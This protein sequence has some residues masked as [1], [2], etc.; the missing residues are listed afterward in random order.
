LPSDT[1]SKNVKDKLRSSDESATMASE[2]V[3]SPYTSEDDDEQDDDN[4]HDDNENDHDENDNANENEQEHG[5]ANENETNADNNNN[6]T[7]D[8][9]N[10]NDDVELMES[11]EKGILNKPS[12]DCEADD[13]GDHAHTGDERGADSP[14]PEEEI[15]TKTTDAP[16]PGDNHNKHQHN[17]YGDEDTYF[18]KIPVPGLPCNGSSLL[19]P[20]KPLTMD[21]MKDRDMRLAPGLCSICLSNYKVC[22]KGKA[23]WAKN[24]CNSRKGG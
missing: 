13:E 3:F 19:D 8:D 24:F 1:I 18:I 10:D 9:E 5:N 16:T 6:S 20:T 17:P 7:K 23:K 2:D 4:D 22:T 12:A 15:L 14:H 21:D 11:M